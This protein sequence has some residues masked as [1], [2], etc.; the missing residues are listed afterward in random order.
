MT[1]FLRKLTGQKRPTQFF[2]E[3]NVRCKLIGILLTTGDNLLTTSDLFQVT[4]PIDQNC[5]EILPKIDQK[6][7][8]N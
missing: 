5:P 8:E 6:L 4:A 2:N 7:I 3:K 1:L